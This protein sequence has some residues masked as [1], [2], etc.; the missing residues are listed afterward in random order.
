MQLTETQKIAI[1]LNDICNLEQERTLL[2]GHFALVA[3]R[4]GVKVKELKKAY[5]IKK[6]VIKA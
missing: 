3:K 1:A 2:K 6:L 5:L 4:H